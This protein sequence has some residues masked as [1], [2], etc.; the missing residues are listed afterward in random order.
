MSG[1]PSY[2]PRRV[3]PSCKVFTGSIFWAKAAQ[4]YDFDRC[5]SQSRMSDMIEPSESPAPNPVSVL[6]ADQNLMAGRLLG[7]SLAGKGGFK[8][9]GIAV[10]VE[11]ALQMFASERA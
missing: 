7:G 10:D 6:V 1:T 5:S 4:N 8:L 11:Q 3:Q 9:V 2:D